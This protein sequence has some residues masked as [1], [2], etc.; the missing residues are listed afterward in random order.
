V[1]RGGSLAGVEEAP[2]GAE[3]R[4]GWGGLHGGINQ[5]GQAEAAGEVV[6]GVACMVSFTTEVQG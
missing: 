6:G 1:D 2:A 3:L 4:G 5:G